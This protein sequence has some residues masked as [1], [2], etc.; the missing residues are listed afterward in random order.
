MMGR[1]RPFPRPAFAPDFDFD[2]APFT[3]AWEIT[4]ACAL[5]CRHCRAEA[6][7]HRNPRELSTEEGLRLV[8]RISELGT[9]VLVVTGGDPL[10]RDDVFEFIVRG[11]GRGLYVALSPSATG[12]AREAAI[13][14]AKEAGAR[15]IHVSLD[16]PTAEKHDGFRGVRG[17]Y[18][19]TLEIMRWAGG[20]GMSLQ[21]GTTVGRWNL[22]DLPDIAAVVEE[23]GASIWSVFFLVPTGRGRCEDTLSAEEHEEVYRWLH[24]YSR[25]AEVRVRTIAGQPYRR[26]AAQEAGEMRPGEGGRGMEALGV[27]DGKGF[28]FVSHTGEVYPSGFL[29]L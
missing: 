14:K 6:I 28:C 13:E 26:L 2:R 29:Q 19:R 10:M 11:A 18:R 22:E 12:R 17:S 7:P 15:S 24:R 1:D 25:T 3:V 9:R 16:G 21:V 27:N 20:L 4:R 23:N 5:A 8:D